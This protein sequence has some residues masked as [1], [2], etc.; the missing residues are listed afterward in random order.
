MFHPGMGISVLPLNCTVTGINVCMIEPRTQKYV[1]RLYSYDRYSVSDVFESCFLSDIISGD[2]IAFA[3]V[4]NA[5]TIFSVSKMRLCPSP[6][7]SFRAIFFPIIICIKKYRPNWYQLAS[8]NTSTKFIKY[9]GFGDD[10]AAGLAQSKRAL[11]FHTSTILFT[12]T[13]RFG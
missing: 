9:Y 3:A 11:I 6:A 10:Q 12:A 7:F 1:S 4:T 8:F 13:G 5:C 2:Y